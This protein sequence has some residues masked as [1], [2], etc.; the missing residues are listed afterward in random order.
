MLSIYNSHPCEHFSKDYLL[1][2]F[3]RFRIY[4]SFKFLNREMASE[5]NKEK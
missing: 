1:N 5:K 3:I 4:S 2:L